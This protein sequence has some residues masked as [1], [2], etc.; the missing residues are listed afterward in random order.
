[1]PLTVTYFPAP[2][3][4]YVTRTC[5]KIAGHAFTDETLTFPEFQANK[6]RFPLGQMPILTLDNGTVVTQSG[7]HARYAGKIAG[8]YPTDPEEQLLC[9][10]IYETCNEL[11]GKVPQHPDAEEKKKLREAF[12]AEALPKYMNFLASKSKGNFFV[13]GKLTIADL[14]LYTVIK[15]IRSGQWD[16]VDK[17]IDSKWPEI[18]ALID[19]LDAHEHVVAHGK[20]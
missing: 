14:M 18:G 1:M 3:R 11:Q 13:N 16:H 17:D 9:D 8:L 15:S 20:L 19:K 2:G 6:A 5:L 10:E 7:A 4:A 12:V